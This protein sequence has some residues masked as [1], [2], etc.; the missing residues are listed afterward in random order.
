MLNKSRSTV[1]IAFV[2]SLFLT[3]LA[4]AI[5]QEINYQGKVTNADGVPLNGTYDMRFYIFNHPTEENELWN[6]PQSV[7]ITDGIFNVSLGAVLPLSED[8]FTSSYLGLEVTIYNDNSIPPWEILSPRQE[9]TSTAYAMRAA[10]AETVAGGVINTVHIMDD[11]VTSA[12]IEDGTVEMADFHDGAVLAELAGNAGSGSGLDADKLDGH[13]TAYFATTT[14]VAQLEARIA[15]LEALLTNVTRNGNDITFSGVNVHV[16]NGTGTTNG[17]PNS[18]GNLTVGYNEVRGTGDDRSGSHNI[19]VGSMHNYSSYGGLVAGRYNTIAGNYASV[20]GGGDNTASGDQ[21]SVSGGSSNTAGGTNASVTGGSHNKATGRGAFVGG[22]GNV[23]S[24]DGNE[25]FGDYTAILGGNQNITGDPDLTDHTLGQNATVSGGH[26]NT[27]SGES[28]SISGGRNNKASG[29]ASFVGGGGGKY[30]LDGNIAF[31]KY[32]SILG[33]TSNTTG[34]VLPI[35]YEDWEYVMYFIYGTDHNLGACSTVSGGWGNNAKGL[36]SSASGGKAN[37]PSGVAASIS[38][39]LLNRASKYSS[40]VIGGFFNEA[41]G[42]YSS[43]SGGRSNTASG[44][45]SS[46]SGGRNNIASGQNSFVGGGG[47]PTQGWG[48]EAYSN[49]SAILGGA[50][51]ITGDKD[52]GIHS[53]GELATISGG[54]ANRAKGG[55]SSI[56]GGQDNTASGSF[57]SINGGLSNETYSNHTTVSGGTLNTANNNYATVSGGHHNTAS[58]ASSTVSGG[59]NNTASNAFDSVVGDYGAV[60]VDSTLVH[61]L[62]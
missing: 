8:I 32:S 49:Y 57:T 26:W 43:V 13:D 31:A 23:N 21:S 58:G 62:E 46:V 40:S 33:G 7:L 47:H 35:W 16:V 48:N 3:S 18:L 17:T 29:L 19:V 2:L 55:W 11:A 20:S 30:V 44:Y 14:T 59:Q 36:S 51:N 25:A 1:I 6:E 37:R 24:V 38:G 42:Y 34:D 60:Y 28:S 22:G 45:Y 54:D 5:P 39:G 41:S 50:Y 4:G 56:T 9:L 12:K 15:Q 10:V 52:S 53:N 61:P 27:A